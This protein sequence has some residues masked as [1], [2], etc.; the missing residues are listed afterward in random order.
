MPELTATTMTR[1][2][3]FLHELELT[4]QQGY[5][6]D[7]AENQPAGRCVGVVIEGVP[8]LAGVSVSAPATRLPLERVPDVADQLRRVARK[9]SSQM[10]R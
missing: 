3:Q 8:F 9:L 5:G 4:R 7:E 10:Q 2:D 1:P 6:I